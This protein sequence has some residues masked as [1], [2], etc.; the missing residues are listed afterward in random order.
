MVSSNGKNLRK[1]FRRKLILTFRQTIKI[2]ISHRKS[3]DITLN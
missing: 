2:K 1:F 3:K